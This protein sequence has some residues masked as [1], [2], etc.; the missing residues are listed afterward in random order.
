MRL[1]HLKRLRIGVSLLYFI[2]ATLL[3]VD[4]RNWF[5]PSVS[6]VVLYPQFV[7]AVLQFMHGA[8]LGATGFILVLLFTFCVGR[9]YCS[10]FCPLGTVQDLTIYFYRRRKRRSAYYRLPNNGLRYSLLAVTVFIFLAGSNFVLN[11]LDPFSSFGRIITNIVRPVGIVVN[12]GGAAILEKFGMYTLVRENWAVMSPLSTG[13]AL[14]TLFVLMWLAALHG[15]IYCNTICPVG[16]LL[17]LVARFSVL[18]LRLDDDS[19]TNCRR[20]IYVCKADCIDLATKTVDMDRCVSCYNCLNICK[21]DAVGFAWRRKSSHD[22]GQNITDPERREFLMNSAYYALA[23]GGLAEPGAVSDSVRKIIQAK[24]TTIPVVRTS[25]VSPP[26]SVSIDRFTSTCTAC[27]LCVSAC[28]PQIL[29]PSLLEYGVSGLMQPRMYFQTGHCNYE[30]TICGEVCPAGAILP[31]AVE[32]KKLTQTGVAKFI[33]ENCV[34]HTDNTACGACSE[35]C[36]TKAVN[37][38]PYANPLGKPLV[39][40]D[41]KPEL[42]VGCGGCEHACP[43]KPYKAIFVDGNPEHKLAQKPV[44]Q[45]VEQEVDYQKDFPF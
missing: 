13:I 24:P 17:G 45:E 38:V 28:P 37:M 15:R 26:G 22:S 31:L 40:P 10:T 5:A 7:P 19:C 3:F 6:S 20:C 33:K 18:K 8:A 39:I 41:V 34:V 42:C 23:L 27:H 29:L 16:T 2:A 32:E 36:P 44:V 21:T 4:F 35:H 25:P 1:N 11:L 30:C 12:N 14:T 9:V 43:T